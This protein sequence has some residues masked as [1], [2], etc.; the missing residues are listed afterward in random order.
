MSTIPTLF[1][2]ISLYDDKDV[3]LRIECSEKY[4]GK[5]KTCLASAGFTCGI[6]QI[7]IPGTPNIHNWV[8]F[9]VSGGMFDAMKQAVLGLLQTA[10]VT[11]VEESFSSAGEMHV[12]LDLTN[13]SVFDK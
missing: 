3:G 12:R 4:S 2:E 8:E 10:G 1:A 9:G 13:K 7:I 6:Q 5:I 11:V